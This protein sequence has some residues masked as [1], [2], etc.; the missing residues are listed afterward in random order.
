[1]RRD[2]TDIIAF[3]NLLR[4]K[5]NSADNGFLQCFHI[6]ADSAAWGG[7]SYIFETS[8]QCFAIRVLPTLIFVIVI[9]WL[10]SMNLFL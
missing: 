6:A 10:H 5:G 9:D 1:M 2:E 8:L 3:P 4:W 7:C